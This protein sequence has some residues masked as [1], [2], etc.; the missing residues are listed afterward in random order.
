MGKTKEEVKQKK[1]VGFTI[2]ITVRV[3]CA[4]QI[5]VLVWPYFD[6]Q[7]GLFASSNVKKA[8]QD[9]VRDKIITS[10]EE[11]G[12]SLLDAAALR[13]W[14]FVRDNMMAVMVW[15]L[16]YIPELQVDVWLHHLFIILGVTLGSDPQLLGKY[17]ALQP[18]IDGIA[19]LLVLGATTMAVQEFCVL[20]Y[21]T[22][23]SYARCQANW[24]NISALTQGVVVLIFFFAL[25]TRL[26]VQHRKEFGPLFL[27]ALLVFAF[28]LV[29]EFKMISV[30]RSIVA[31]ARRKSDQTT[32]ST[33]NELV[34]QNK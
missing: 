5:F 25:P 13:A 26:V 31:H 33:G 3:S 23:A 15:E 12:M 7:A 1:I 6:M 14:V 29:L 4:I 30:K 8:Y 18:F 21:H 19:F 32:V 17:S 16:A 20:M 2:K 9:Q 22:N 11:A 28:L 34:D 10:C 27:I 24:M